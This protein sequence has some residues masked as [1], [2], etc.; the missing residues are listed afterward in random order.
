[1]RKRRLMTQRLLLPSNG[2]K[3]TTVNELLERTQCFLNG[4]D[5]LRAAERREAFRRFAER[6]EELEAWC[7]ANTTDWGPRL[8]G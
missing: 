2:Q 8:R 3:K 1:M 7:E 5:G 4:V 6:L